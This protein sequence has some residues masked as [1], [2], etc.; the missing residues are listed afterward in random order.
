MKIIYNKIIPFKG[1]LAINLF[2]FLFARNK[3]TEVDINHEKI[4]TEQMKELLYV[5]FYILY[6]LEYIIRW[7]IPFFKM[8]LPDSHKIYRSISF[9]QEAYKYETDLE[10][11]K[12]RKRYNWIKYIKKLGYVEREY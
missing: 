2:G 5:L 9:E 1:F 10:Y 7:F 11:L 6:I 12:N 3:L 4:H 8:S